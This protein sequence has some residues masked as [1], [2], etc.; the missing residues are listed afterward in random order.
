MAGDWI[1]MRTDLYRDPK[2]CVI[3][4]AMMSRDGE[5]ARYVS[6]MNQRDMTVTRNVTRNATVGAL[7]T[8]WGVMRHRGKPF[9]GDLIC[10]GVSISIIDDVADLPGFGAAM[11]SVGWVVETDEGIVFPSFF[12][13]Y[14][15]DPTE[16]KASASAERQRRYR[17]SQ[18]KKSD[19]TRDVTRDVTVTHREEKRREEKERA[20]ATSAD[21][22]PANPK[23]EQ[24]GT[25]L[26]EDWQ[27]DP[28]LTAWA[29]K[30]RPD[31]NLQRE[32][33]GFRDYW[34]SRAGKDARKASW[35]LTFRNWIRNSRN[36]SRPQT[37][38]GGSRAAGRNLL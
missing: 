27:P 8:V 38:I 22:L 20:C 37:Q 5:L 18:K 36:G 6:Q 14:N 31:L 33:A 2:V 23:R 12:A 11:A 35:P 9:C 32:I 3:A 19:V 30:E 10:R 24:S 1:K 34:H 28:E 25:R 17:E 21:V 29:A 4:D 26:P 7:V 13:E 16:K 15:V